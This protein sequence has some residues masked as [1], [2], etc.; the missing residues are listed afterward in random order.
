MGRS[1]DVEVI[2]DVNRKAYRRQLHRLVRPLP[3]VV[4][5][6]NEVARIDERRDG[7]ASRIDLQRI[8]PILL[9][10]RAYVYNPEGRT[11]LPLRDGKAL[12]DA[13]TIVVGQ[14]HLPTRELPLR[15]RSSLLSSDCAPDTQ[16]HAGGGEDDVGSH[17]A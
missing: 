4:R 17:E 13:D 1:D 2:S 6:R 14:R 8:Q 11:R 5:R 10:R 16:K 3:C 12:D 7:T 9:T 15:N